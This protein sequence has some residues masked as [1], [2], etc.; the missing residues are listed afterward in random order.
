M[1]K[2]ILLV[3][4]VGTALMCSG[5]GK[6]KTLVCTKTE[7]ATGMTIT[8]EMS[9]DFKNDSIQTI[10]MDMNVKLDS[11]Y[12]KYKDTIKESLEQQY[13]KYKDAKG[14]KYSADVKDDVISF[15]L[16]IDNKAISKETRTGLKLSGSEKYSVN[17]KTLEDQG[18]SCK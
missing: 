16:T 12:V 2:K 18:Y 17:K 6:T 7:D 4:V 14:V 10:K 8:S 3:A 13:S 1:K 11:S 9:T 5:C 15:S